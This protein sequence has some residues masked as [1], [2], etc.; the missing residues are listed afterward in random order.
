MSVDDILFPPCPV[1]GLQRRRTPH[2][3]VHRQS[4]DAEC[5]E[6]P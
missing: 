3:W 4:G 5:E 6:Q 2:G 1:C